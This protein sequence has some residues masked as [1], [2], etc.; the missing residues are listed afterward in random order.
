MIVFGEKDDSFI[1]NVTTVF[2]QCREKNVTFNAKKMVIGFD[3]VP[4]VGHEISATVSICPKN[5]SKV[6]FSSVNLIP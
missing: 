1:R 2:Q 3:T 5:V 4:F 6:Q